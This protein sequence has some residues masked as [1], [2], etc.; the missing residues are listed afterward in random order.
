M[1]LNDDADVA[2]LVDGGEKMVEAAVG[3]GEF[4]VGDGGGNHKSAGLNAIGN[5]RVRGA[6][7]FLD[8]F[9]GDARRARAADFGPHRIEVIRDIHDF[10]FA[11]GAF[12]RRRALRESGGGHDV[13][14]AQDGG[15]E[16]APKEDFS[17]HEFICTRD[18]ITAIK[19]D[20]G[21]KRFKPPEVDIDGSVPDGAAARH[22]DAREFAFGEERAEDADGGPHLSDEVI[23]GV[24]VFFVL[25]F[26]FNIVGGGVA[27]DLAA[28][29]EEEIDLVGDVRKGRDVFE[30]RRAVS[31]ESGGHKGEGG[32]F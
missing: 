16:V 12:D 4:A 22:G 8:P 25:D 5:D 27:F 21:S 19:V 7:E 26:D 6:F 24:G 15:A 13:G 1:F 3:E 9:D 14:G 31:K 32:V 2:E 23:A 17:T 30:R 28:K 18:D 10:R 29:F 11:G 20:D